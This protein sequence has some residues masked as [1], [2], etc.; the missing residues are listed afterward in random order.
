MQLLTSLIVK[1][2]MLHYLMGRGQ[3]NSRRVKGVCGT[4]FVLTWSAYSSSCYTPPWSVRIRFRTPREG[5]GISPTTCFFF[6]FSCLYFLK[7]KKSDFFWKTKKNQISIFKKLIFLIWTFFRNCMF[8]K[9]WKNLFSI[10]FIWKI[11]EFEY[12]S[13]LNKFHIWTNFEFKQF[14]KFEYFSNL[15]NFK[16]QCFWNLNH[17][18]IQFFSIWTKIKK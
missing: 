16:F 6:L 15:W 7:I 13:I 1:F 14:L 2:G 11:S 17:F 18:Q 10:F 4:P 8:S 5:V 12:F 3:I 9:M